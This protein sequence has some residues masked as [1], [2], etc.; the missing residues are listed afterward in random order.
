MDP[1]FYVEGDSPSVPVITDNAPV[2]TAD[3]DPVEPHA[4]QPAEP[5]GGAPRVRPPRT[6]PFG[7]AKLLRFVAV[8]LILGAFGSLSGIGGVTAAAPIAEHDLEQ[9]AQGTLGPALTG[10]LSHQ[11]ETGSFAG[12]EPGGGILS[13]SGATTIILAVLVPSPDGAVCA[14]G[15]II[16]GSPPDVR[17]DPTGEACQ[18]T[19]MDQAAAAITAAD[20]TATSR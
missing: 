12:F 6:L 13:A 18:R 7:G 3:G 15:G 14:Y 5:A 8:A 10:A 1:E 11:S 16:N 17:L 20:S 9:I 2:V 4:G 19:V